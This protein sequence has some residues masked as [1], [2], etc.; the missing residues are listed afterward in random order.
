[1][2]LGG[3]A[4]CCDCVEKSAPILLGLIC[5]RPREFGDCLIEFSAVAKIA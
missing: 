1:M 5:V 3:D 2:R 4:P